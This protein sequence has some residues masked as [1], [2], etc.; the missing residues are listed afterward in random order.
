[1]FLLNAR[2]LGVDGKIMLK[3]TID[4]Q[5]ESMWLDSSGSEQGPVV[6][7]CEHGNEPGSIK[8]YKNFD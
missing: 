6:S 7:S 8:C 1:M 4:K 5:N 2:D 3:W